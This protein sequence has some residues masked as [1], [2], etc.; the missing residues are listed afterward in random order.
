MRV[1]ITLSYNGSIFFGFQSQTS[2]Q[3]T[4]ATALQNSFK[5]IG[6]T[7][8][9]HASGRTDRNVHATAQVIHID[10]PSYWSDFKKLKTHLNVNLSPHIVIRRIEI[11]NEDFHARYSAKSRV[12]RYI[13]ST[14]RPDPFRAKFITFV[15]DFD[16]SVMRNAMKEFIGKHDFEWFKKNGSPTSSDVRSIKKT[17]MYEHNG[18]TILYFEADGYLRSQIRMMVYMLLE[19]SQNKLPLS[20]ISEQLTKQVRH[21]TNLAPP[22]GLYLAKVKY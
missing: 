17:F 2:T 12:Y 4:V 19:V 22:N 15:K 18:C 5:K 9:L 20:A 16:K 8:K 10:L 13:L 1:K 3:N 14:S 6:I 11:V 21:S 7:S